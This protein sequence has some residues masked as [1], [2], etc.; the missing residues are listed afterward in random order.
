MQTFKKNEIVRKKDPKRIRAKQAL[1]Q[2]LTSALAE[3]GNLA[4]QLTSQKKASDVVTSHYD[5]SKTPLDRFL[6]NVDESYKHRINQQILGDLLSKAQEDLQKA[7]MDT[8]TRQRIHKTLN[9]IYR[10]GVIRPRRLPKARS[11]YHWQ[12]ASP[13]ESWS[14]MGDKGEPEIRPNLTCGKVRLHYD[15]KDEHYIS[16]TVDI[17]TVIRRQAG[18]AKRRP[19]RFGRRDPEFVSRCKG[20]VGRI[21][22]LT[23]PRVH[24]HCASFDNEA[25]RFSMR[26]FQDRVS[27]LPEH[28]DK[29]V[30]EIIALCKKSTDDDDYIRMVEFCEP[31]I[32]LNPD[33]LR[34]ELKNI[35]KGAR[36]VL[37]L[38]NESGSDSEDEPDV[39]VVPAPRARRR[40]VMEDI[41]TDDDDNSFASSDEEEEEDPIDL[42]SRSS[43]QTQGARLRILKQSGGKD[44][45]VNGGSSS[46]A[47]RA[48]LKEERRDIEDDRQLRPVV[49][50]PGRPDVEEEEPVVEDLDAMRLADLK[51]KA[52]G[53]GLTDDQVAEFGNRSRKTTYVAAI[54]AKEAG[55]I[56]EEE[57]V[58]EEESEEE[59]PARPDVEE[60]E[61]VVGE[62]LDAMGLTELKAKA[63][64]LGLT[65]E[66]VAEFGN[67][68]RKDTYVAA[69]RAKE[70]GE[71]REEEPTRPDIEEETD[72]EEPT[73]PDVEEESEEEEP[74]AE[75]LDAMRLADLKAKAEGLG[76]TDDQV[77]EFGNRSRKDTYVAAI[78]AKEAGEIDEEEPFR[79]DVEEETDEEVQEDPRGMAPEEAVIRAEEAARQAEESARQ[80]AAAAD[81]VEQ[82]LE[83]LQ[84]SELKE[85][86]TQLGLTDDQVGDFG[87]RSFKDTY[88]AAIRAKE[89][90]EI[91][92]E[93]ESEEESED[94][95]SMSREKLENYFD[96]LAGTPETVDSDPEQEEE[97]PVGE[98]LDAMG[99]ADLKAK[100][101]GL[102]L[103]DDQVAEFGNRSRKDTYIAAIR[104]K[105]AG[106]IREEEPVR[107]DVEEESEEEEPARPDVEEES[108]EEEP[109]VEDL[110]AM[111]LTELKAKAEGLGL[112]DEQ[113]AE[114]GNRSRKDTYIAAIRAKEA[115][116]IDEA[117]PQMPPQQ[118][119][120][121]RSELEPRQ[122]GRTQTNLGEGYALE[123]RDTL[124]ALTTDLTSRPYIPSGE[125]TE[126][127]A[128]MT[129]DWASSEDELNFAEDSEMEESMQFAESSAV[130]HTESGSF[131]F[132]ESSAVETDSDN[133]V[134]TSITDKT[135]SGLEFAESS[136][137]DSDSAKEHGSS[138]GLGWAESSDYD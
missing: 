12:F 46:V 109:V 124:S 29:S 41:S 9:I 13:Y 135:S 90:G 18:A 89:A 74:A 130:E 138:S 43:L 27:R 93:E 87:N 48:A 128:N 84:L 116:E 17:G 20:V 61:P 47:I 78:R 40:L 96:L 110:D 44:Y 92:D 24:S 119:S 120:E 65:D 37:M 108:E 72:E 56:D 83:E 45:G 127:V 100:A 76:L 133:D 88:I 104:A 33:G 23:Q 64:G 50:E 30:E 82:K 114:F 102:G 80:A 101:E 122:L 112:T 86:A 111:R 79:A 55:E 15:N 32:H 59:E 99:L 31:T 35:S 126:M 58:V 129:D 51:A 69:I 2:K 4:S 106:E 134:V 95:G 38:G 81:E 67:R 25:N 107:P 28:L 131:E 53:L 68:S 63:E 85:K 1:V 62:D 21:L 121:S 115:G 94:V 10:K 19:Y 91:D 97:E 123:S 16:N 52:E 75:D 137:V 71:I 118:L 66:Q 113:V 49:V 8:V 60:E 54:R 3:E 22:R 14:Q 5:A 39:V 70:A 36:V 132:A 7:Q 11:K 77:A 42:M 125:L 103:T 34:R 105:E 136:A 117:V 57:P 73:R 6:K 26:V 98:D